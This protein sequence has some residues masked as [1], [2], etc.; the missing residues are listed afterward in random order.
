MTGPVTKLNARHFAR[1]STGLIRWQN[2]RLTAIL[3]RSESI[4]GEQSP[5]FINGVRSAILLSGLVE[6]DHSKI[7]DSAIYDSMHISIRENIRPLF[8]NR[9]YIPS[10]LKSIAWNAGTTGR[11]QI[12]ALALPIA[13][14]DVLTPGDDW[15]RRPISR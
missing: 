7:V 2:A 13:I 9:R 5:A 12:H 3:T 6:L 8:H 15:F 10:R 4:L 14:P 11:P 1:L